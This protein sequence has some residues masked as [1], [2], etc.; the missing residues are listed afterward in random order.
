MNLDFLKNISIAEAETKVRKT[1]ETKSKFP[2]DADIRIY[3]S[4]AVYP[5]PALVAAWDLEYRN[6]P[7]DPKGKPEGN[8]IDVIDS[9]DW[10]QAKNLPMSL[11]F[12]AACARKQGK[13]DLFASVGY[14]ENGEPATSVLTQ[15]ASTFGK[16]FLETLK[17]VY[18]APVAEELEANGFVDLSIVMSQPP[19][20]SPNDI[21]HIP[22]VVS[23]GDKA[24]ELTYERRENLNIYAMVLASTIQQQAKP[25]TTVADAESYGTTVNSLSEDETSG[26]A[27]DHEPIEETEEA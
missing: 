26:P 25:A 27:I 2:V 22:K 20:K 6:K 3:K 13:V 1:G 21:Y 9:R 23:R 10:A 12:V 19:F 8:G 24:G 11:I 4:G 14:N 16:Q 15:G 17:E 5:S 18:G 7:A